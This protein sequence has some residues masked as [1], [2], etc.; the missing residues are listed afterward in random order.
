V[1]HPKWGEAPLAVVYADPDARLDEQTVIETCRSSLGSYKKP[2]AVI[3]RDE[4]MPRSPVGKVQR[5]VIREP[6]WAGQSRR[7]AGS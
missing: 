3:F 5:K 6:F 4:P 1:P 7:V 2:S